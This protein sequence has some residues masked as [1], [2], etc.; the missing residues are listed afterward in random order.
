MFLLFL[1][2]SAAYESAELLSKLLL[3]PTPLL[4]YLS[5]RACG[6]HDAGVRGLLPALLKTSSLVRLNLADNGLRNFALPLV[7]VMAD[8]AAME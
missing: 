4:R 1:L 8:Q 6:L 2:T 5:L 7:Q 3:S